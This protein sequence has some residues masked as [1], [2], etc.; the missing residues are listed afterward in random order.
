MG[1]PDN[2][3][4]WSKVNKTDGCWLWIGATDRRYGSFSWSGRRLAKAHRISWELAHGPIPDGMC[5]LH[6]CDVPLC[7]RP[8]HL[9]L[10]TQK[11]N[12]RDAFRKGRM[13]GR[14]TA[15][16]E[17]IDGSRLTRDDVLAIRESD[18]SA[19]V[20]A[21]RLGVCKSTVVRARNGSCWSHL[22]L[23]SEP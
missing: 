6:R 13:E 4:F 19:S 2:V 21:Q 7:V 16:G 10:G 22:P 8:A 12:L 15:H 5:V 14:R 9:F 23:R 1:N 11:D 17:Q 3:R 18:A 20:L